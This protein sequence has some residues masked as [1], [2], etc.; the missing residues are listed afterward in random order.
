LLPGEEKIFFCLSG[1][2][3]SINPR[4]KRL[5]LEVQDNPMTYTGLVPACQ[6]TSLVREEHGL[7]QRD[8]EREALGP[9]EGM[10]GMGPT[11]LYGFL[12]FFMLGLQ[13]GK[14]APATQIFLQLLGNPKSP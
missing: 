7:D 1:C 12:K 13:L 8:E 6:T 2:K 14:D 3:A 5:R 11:L 9:R 4:E 10:P